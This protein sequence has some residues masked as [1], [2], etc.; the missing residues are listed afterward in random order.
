MGI[1]RFF[2]INLF[3]IKLRKYDNLLSKE[4]ENIKYWGDNY[5][6]SNRSYFSS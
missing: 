3:L 2:L 5:E 1:R 4:E 6:N